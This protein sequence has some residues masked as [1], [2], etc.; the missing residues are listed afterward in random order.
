MRI[1]NS[2]CV[3]IGDS[4]SDYE[5]SNSLGLSFYLADWGKISIFPDN[6]EVLRLKHLYHFWI[7]S[8][9]RYQSSEI[10]DI[11]NKIFRGEVN[12]FIGSGFSL[13]AGLDSWDEL[14]ASILNYIPD[15]LEQGNLT[16][17][18][19]IF[20][21]QNPILGKRKI[22]QL[23]NERLNTNNDSQKHYYLSHLPIGRIWTTNFD[24]LIEN[25]IDN[26]KLIV[27]DANLDPRGDRMQ[28]IKVNGS[29]VSINS[30]IILGD[31]DFENL[32]R[33][34]PQLIK[35]LESD[36]SSRSMIFLG[37][38]FQDPLQ[39]KIL[40]DYRANIRERGV[41]I[42]FSVI[43]NSLG[44]NQITVEEIEDM[45]IKAIAVPNWEDVIGFLAEIYWETRQ[46]YVVISGTTPNKITENQHEF[47]Y[48]LGY[49]LVKI[50]FSI[51]IGSGIGVSSIIIDGAY[52]ACQEFNHDHRKRIIKYSRILSR[53]DFFN[54]DNTLKN[55]A[56]ERLDRLITSKGSLKF[57]EN[58]KGKDRYD[59]M[60]REMFNDCELCISISGI[61]KVVEGS[62]FT[63]NRGMLF[64]KE[65]AVQKSIPY[66]PLPY[67]DGFAKEEFDRLSVTDFAYF[68]EDIQPA[69]GILN[70]DNISSQK[71]G[72]ISAQIA[73]RLILH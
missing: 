4:Y 62:A 47:L 17:L 20:H 55:R 13:D 46:H 29:V 10:E 53:T 65:L 32:H 8:L 33:I 43:K 59:S 11:V 9:I 35:E 50:G 52:D 34:R 70:N 24:P 60:R 19:D 67:M 36:L 25:H 23:L 16:R 40:A 15:E 61:H 22:G 1:K 3:Y 56:L 71:A 6:I 48:S 45:G 72:E 12:F 14:V 54:D 66:L 37:C 27:E 2:E 39:R 41:P 57:V 63:K 68:H 73:R 69:F 38:G 30:E 18:I 58:S 21:K 44:E 49:N 64:E 42:H 5:I 31:S 28:V 26:P 7:Y 51:K